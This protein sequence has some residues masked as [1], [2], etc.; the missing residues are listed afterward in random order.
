MSRN[1]VRL[2]GLVAAT[3][4][5]SGAFAGVPG[6]A[7]GDGDVDFADFVIL[8]TCQLGPSVSVSQ[9]CAAA[10]DADA[11]F[12][13][14]LADLA[15]FARCF[16]GTGVAGDPLCQPH[17]AQVVNGCLVVTG[18]AADSTLALR[19][20]AGVPSV[21][22]ID[23]GNDGVADFAF[24]RSSFNC[25][26]I[27]ARAGD[28]T[29]FI[30]ET[31]GVFTD[32]E[33]TT[34]HGGSGNDT[35]I[36][37]TGGEVLDGG[38]GND[39]IQANGGD[40]RIVWNPG[41]G[42][43]AIDG[44][45]GSDTV[46]INGD[47]FAE[48]FTITANGTRVR[49]D[50]VT[51]Q[52]FFLDIG[53]CE[54]LVLNCNG[55]N[56]S[57][58][59]TGN[60][61]ALIQ[62][63]VD[64][65]SGDDTLLGSNGADVLIGG[66]NNDS[67]D[68]NQ[69]NDT[70][71]MGLGNDTFNWDPGDGSDIVEG[72]GGNDKIV[73]NGANVSEIFDFSA[74]GSR[75]RF[76]RNVASIVLDVAGVEQ[77]D[78]NALGGADAVNVSNLAGTGVSQVSVELAATLG[79]SAGDVATDTV[80]L[81][82]TT[83]A[84]TFTFNAS[85][86][87]TVGRLGADIRVHGYEATDQ[88]AVVGVG[89]DTVV[90]NG[91]NNPDAIT[92]T[93]SGT[94][95]IID[96]TGFGCLVAVSGALSLAVNG[97]GGNDNISCGNGLATIV[98]ITIDG[99]PGDDTIL[100]GDGGETLIGGDDNDFIDGNRGNDTILMG[101]GNDT[102]NWDPGDGSDIIEGQGG[103]DKIVFNGANISENLM[104]GANGSRVRFT[105]DVAAITLDINGVE[106][107]DLNALGG[108]DTLTVNSLAGTGLAQ[109]TIDLSASVGSGTADGAAD[110]VV[111]NGTTGAD[112]FSFSGNGT[113]TI[114]HF[115][116]DIRVRSLE[117]SDLIS[118]TGV[119]GDTVQING[120]IGPDTI[121][122]TAAGTQAAITATGY[123]APVLIGGALSLV[124]NG[125]AG[126]DN[127]SCSNG[128]STI[129]PIT[130]DG[131]PGDDTILGGDGNDTLIGG[132]DND[133]I[134]GNRG[135]DTILM[136]LGNDTFN[137]DP[138]DGSDIIE[139]QGGTDTVMFNGANITENLQ[140]SANGSRARFTRDVA[141]ITLDMSG[142]ELFNLRAL[143]GADTITVNDISG[144]GLSSVSVDL[145]G[146]VGGTAGDGAADSIIVNGT[147][148]NDTIQVNAVSG[149]VEVSGLPTFVRVSH[150]EAAN[151]RLTI[152]GLNGADVISVG[153][154]V[155]A[156]IQVTSNP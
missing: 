5:S 127:I 97:L 107:F 16:R 27:D 43:D 45:L 81:N 44:G 82:G 119:G 91:S 59:C 111:I 3:L 128:L 4:C 11:D 138:G 116:A 130:I 156:L 77:F 85:G 80:T 113:H 150:S 32:T 152:N 98:P 144:T 123:T 19:L 133:F 110:T 7:D 95:A 14:D 10:C 74:N 69:G 132:D 73:F 22:E 24:S 153:P 117:A 68:G 31:N 35:L 75:L 18:T 141:A 103:N 122:V 46:E 86:G 23:V 108:A 41:D 118:V 112:T 100:G 50:R 99:G 49:F 36:G 56:D 38:S 54:S 37:G 129:V 84:D 21:L 145:S 33:T 90:I 67:I 53:G 143:G 28:D 52:P 142:V 58:T 105:R 65:G 106:Q 34:I 2:C 149:A 9:S 140:L 154:G 125:L 39:I 104:I 70:I 15:I 26:D 87:Y 61:A 29:A 17:R 146:T 20:R 30:D 151:D 126:N 124:V 71:L 78:L 83:A 42:S 96:G 139:G 25:I 12:D 135:N 79:G 134:D 92:V 101:L 121:A 102:F 13:V 1:W 136:G 6:D 115:A 131:G 76:T 47:D 8:S 48:Q 40:D 88:F 64:G 66:D 147:A 93:A 148:G 120:S 89:G 57:L 155:T 109:V 114:V 51:P 137:W 63:T 62:I 94:Q 55:G 72:Q 60:L